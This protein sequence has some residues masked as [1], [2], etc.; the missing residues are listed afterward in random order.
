MRSHSQGH[1]CQRGVGQGSRK[2]MR[3]YH[4]QKA[5]L[6]GSA[7]TASAGHGFCRH[8]AV[9][10]NFRATIGVLN[11]FVPGNIKRVVVG[12]DIERWL[13]ESKH[14]QACS[15]LQNQM[16]RASKIW[17]RNS[18]NSEPAERP[19]RWSMTSVDTGTPT[20]LNQSSVSIPDSRT[21]SSSSMG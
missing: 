10:D 12:E 9:M 6:S 21:I 18:P 16:L 7:A 4:V 1:T 17:K 2:N 11:L 5:D 13:K 15:G 3:C 19:L 20:P 14:G 8:F